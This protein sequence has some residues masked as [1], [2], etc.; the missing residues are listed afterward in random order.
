MNC[1]QDIAG[2]SSFFPVKLLSGHSM[3]ARCNFIFIFTSFFF[4]PGSSVELV[5]GGSDKWFQPSLANVGDLDNT[6]NETQGKT[7]LRPA[8]GA[9]RWK[10]AR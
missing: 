7:H 6:G 9:G 10:A 5:Y 2:I 1:W 8:H 3:G 4:K